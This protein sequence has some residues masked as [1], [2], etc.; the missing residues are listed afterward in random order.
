MGHCGSSEE[1]ALLRYVERGYVRLIKLIGA[2]RALMT[3][4]PVEMCNKLDSTASSITT[5]QL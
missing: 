1:F 4:K 5:E 3:L 2:V